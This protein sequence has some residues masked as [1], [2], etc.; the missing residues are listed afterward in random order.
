[1]EFKSHIPEQ[2]LVDYALGHITDKAKSRNI[3]EHTKQCNACKNV[4]ES[5]QTFA[6]KSIHG[7]EPPPGL[8]EKL[9]ETIMKEQKPVKRKKKPAIIFAISSLAVLLC[10]VAGMVL[11]DPAKTYK[12]VQHD[13]IEDEGLQSNPQTKQSAI[14]PVANFDHLTGQIWL[15][16][17]TQE[18]LL[19]VNGLQQIK[20]RD[21]QLW[22]VYDNDDVEGEILL[23]ENGTSRVF[24]KGEDVERFKWIKASLEPLGGSDKPTGPDTF[25]VPLG[26]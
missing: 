11:N 17:R 2:M 13:A 9:R 25:I 18:M 10:L 23:I 6:G 19:E 22:I 20:N 1:M 21:Y 14:T 26:F 7:V 3:A 16:D 24:I 5:W 12:M 8:K 4:L 15:N